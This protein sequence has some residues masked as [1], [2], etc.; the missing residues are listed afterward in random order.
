[1]KSK[2][3]A[4]SLLILLSQTSLAT[5]IR[6]EPVA[7]PSLNAIKSGGVISIESDRFFRWRGTNFSKYDTDVE[8]HFSIYEQ[9]AKTE[10]EAL[11]KVK[12]NLKLLSHVDGVFP[13]PG[14]KNAWVCNYFNENPQV[15]AIAWTQSYDF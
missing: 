10:A 14:E 11:S 4:L 6:V 13:L 8:W 3:G 15:V 5:P 7:C 1:M 12:A 9:F 2:L